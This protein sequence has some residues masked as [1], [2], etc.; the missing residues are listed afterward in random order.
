MI[1]NR[2]LVFTFTLQGIRK[3]KEAFTFTPGQRVT[4]ARMDNIRGR[5]ATRLLEIK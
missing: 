3:R 5:I 2:R 4:W 1:I